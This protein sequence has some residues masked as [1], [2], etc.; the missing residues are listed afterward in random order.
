MQEETVERRVS[1]LDIL[2]NSDRYDLPKV[3]WREVILIED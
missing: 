1:V 3:W 2:R